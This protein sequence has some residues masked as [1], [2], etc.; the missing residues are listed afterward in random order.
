MTSGVQITPAAK[1]MSIKGKADY[2]VI[3][4][5]SFNIANDEKVGFDAKNYL[6][7][8]NDSKSS[9]IDGTLSGAGNIY[10]VNPNGVIFGSDS[11]VNVGNLS[12]STRPL[13]KVDR[14]AFLRGQDPLANAASNVGGD[15]VNL[16]DIKA[17]KVLLE[18]NT[19][20]LTNNISNTNLN[21]RALTGVNVGF[22]D[23][24]KPAT[25]VNKTQ[26]T[27]PLDD[28]SINNFKNS[29]NN[30]SFK[31]LDGKTD[32]SS[33]KF[34]P[35]YSVRNIY[36][37]QN[38]RNNPTGKYMLTD[39]IDASL[40]RFWNGEDFTSDDFKDVKN[41]KFEYSL[42]DYKGNMLKLD[43]STTGHTYYVAEL[44]KVEDFDIS[45]IVY[46]FEVTYS[47]TDKNNKSQK[48]VITL[49]IEPNAEG[50]DHRVPYDYYNHK[51]YI[52]LEDKSGTVERVDFWMDENHT[53][54][55]T[56]DHGVTST[57]DYYDYYYENGVKTTIPTE[58]PDTGYIN[59]NNQNN[60][61]IL[62]G[63]E[64]INDLT[65]VSAIRDNPE[66]VKKVL[67]AITPLTFLKADHF[68]AACGFYKCDF[69][70]E[71]SAQ[72]NRD[73]KD[74]SLPLGFGYV[75]DLNKEMINQFQ[76]KFFTLPYA[77]IGHESAPFSGMIDG[78]GFSLKNV[79]INGNT[80]GNFI[81]YTQGSVDSS[82]PR[83]SYMTAEKAIV[84]S[85]L[86]NV[87]LIGWLDGDY[88]VK[89]LTLEYPDII[90][91]TSKENETGGGLTVGYYKSG[92]L[93]TST[94]EYKENYWLLGNIDNPDGH[95]SGLN[96]ISQSPIYPYLGDAYNKLPT[97]QYTESDYTETDAENAQL[98][99]LGETALLAGA[100][101]M[102]ITKDN[103][104]IC[105]YQN[106][107]GSEGKA[108]NIVHPSS[109]ETDNKY[110]YNLLINWDSFNVGKYSSVL[111]D[112]GLVGQLPDGRQGTF[113]Y[114][115]LVKNPVTIEG[116]V[117]GGNELYLV[118][119]G[120]ITLTLDS[121]VNTSALYLS[122][123]D[124][125]KFNWEY[126]YK[127]KR[128]SSK[129]GF[130]G[131]A[132]VVKSE[133]EMQNKPDYITGKDVKEHAKNFTYKDSAKASAN[134]ELK[135]DI[136][137]FA[138]V[139]TNQAGMGIV[140]LEGKNI[141]T[142]NRSLYSSTPERYIVTDGGE[143]K[144][145]AADLHYANNGVRYTSSKIP[146][147]NNFGEGVSTKQF[148]EDIDVKGTTNR[149]G[150]AL[151]NTLYAYNI[152][153]DEERTL[154][155][156]ELYYLVRNV[157]ELQ[158]MQNNPDEQYLLGR[159]IDAS[160]TKNWNYG[161]GFAPIFG[162][163]A[164]KTSSI[165]GP[166]TGVFDGNGF[167]IKNMYINRPDDEGVGLFS[168]TQDATLK[169]VVFEGGSVTGYSN[170]GALIGT[171][172]G[173][174]V[175][176]TVSDVSVTGVGE[177]GQA[178]GG[179]VGS[180]EASKVVGS[181]HNATVAGTNE[182]YDIGGLVGAATDNSVIIGFTGEDTAI[183]AAKP[184][185]GGVGGLVGN[186]D[187][188][189]VKGYNQGTVSSSAGGSLGGLAGRIGNISTVSGFNIGN[190]G[191]ANTK[192]AGGLVGE[193]ANTN[194]DG[195]VL[196]YNLGT[197]SA[198]N[199][200]GLT[201]YISNSTWSS[202][203]KLKLAGE[204]TGSME[205]L[206]G[207]A[208]SNGSLSFTTWT[209]GI[210]KA[211]LQTISGNVFGADRLD[212]TRPDPSDWSKVLLDIEKMPNNNTTWYIKE[213]ESYP[214]LNKY[215]TS[216]DE[217]ILDEVVLP[218]DYTY[219]AKVQ[220]FNK[221][222]CQSALSE[223]LEGKPIKP[224][225]TGAFKIDPTASIAG[226][227]KDAGDY[228]LT[229]TWI[230][231]YKFNTNPFITATIKPRKL[232]LD[233][234]K[235]TTK[236]YYTSGFS[237]NYDGTTSSDSLSGSKLYLST[238]YADSSV[239]IDGKMVT[240]YAIKI[241]TTD[242]SSEMQRELNEEDGTK[243]KVVNLKVPG[244]FN[245]KNVAEAD[246]VTFKNGMTLG[247]SRGRNYI[248]DTTGLSGNPTNGICIEDNNIVVKNCKIK[249]MELTLTKT[250]DASDYFTKEYDGT[251]D[252]IGDIDLS[253]IFIVD[254]S[255]LT[256][257]L[258]E[259]I[260][261]NNFGVKITGL[262]E[263]KYVKKDGS[264]YVDDATAGKSKSVNFNFDNIEVVGETENYQLRFSESSGTKTYGNSLKVSDGKI[265]IS[266]IGIINPMVLKLKQKSDVTLSKEY[267]ATTDVYDSLGNPVTS[268]G[269]IFEIDKTGIEEKY[270]TV[271][272]DEI[273]N[274]KFNDIY[275]AKYEDANAGTD[276][277]IWFQYNSSS[278]PKWFD[279][280]NYT[281]ESITTIGGPYNR[282]V[283]TFVSTGDIT[284]K[285]LK[286]T[287]IDSSSLNKTYDGDTS[288]YTDLSEVFAIGELSS[289]E[290]E[291]IQNEVAQLKLNNGIIGVY[292]DANIGSGKRIL[293]GDIDTQWFTTKDSSSNV[294]A[295][296]Y[297]VVMDTVGDKKGIL[298][299]GSITPMNIYIE[300][301][302]KIYDGNSDVTFGTGDNADSVTL[303][304]FWGEDN[305]YF[306]LV[307]NENGG[308]IA[309]L[310]SGKDVIDN[311]YELNLANYSEKLS[312]VQTGGESGLLSNYQLV[313]NPTTNAWTAKGDIT[314]LT[315]KLTP[316]DS[317]VYD[318]KDYSS[319]DSSKIGITDE[320]GNI[321]TLCG[322]DKLIVET[323]STGINASGDSDGYV[324]KINN[325]AIDDG[326]GGK[327][328]TVSVIDG[329]LVITPKKI[330]ITVTDNKEYDGKAYTDNGS[331]K[332]IFTDENGNIITLCGNDKLSIETSSTGINASG[333]SDGYVLK[334]NNYTIDDG[335][336]G[337]NYVV[338]MS[339]GKLYIKPRTIELSFKGTPITK[340]YDGTTDTE[341][342]LSDLF[343]LYGTDGLLSE[344]YE[345][346]LKVYGKFADAEPGKNKVVDF[347]TTVG[348]NYTLVFKDLN[349]NI[350]QPSSIVGEI[351][352]KP[353]PPEP[354][355]PEPEIKSDIT[356]GTLLRNDS[357][358]MVFEALNVNAA[359]TRPSEDNRDDGVIGAAPN[360]VGLTAE[361][362]ARLADSYNK[363][364][365]DDSSADEKKKKKIG[366]KKSS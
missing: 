364:S 280:G 302:S 62:P 293:F 338:S 18:G 279:N 260:K 206:G 248:L 300:K 88:K 245:S 142:T 119:P 312:L 139:N 147:Y 198:T 60:I 321:I 75:Y 48:F 294:N 131:N 316:N 58:K 287:R 151:L 56:D 178:I 246:S 92:V 221:S 282:D 190:V 76:T 241:N 81:D 164:S 324:L 112:C 224:Q 254:T 207:K 213:E 104:K 337:K 283:A 157:Y 66:G 304:G 317:K 218:T 153:S 136:I 243:T 184:Q 46:G 169:N 25:E 339:D 176:G 107:D 55:K 186:A 113:N 349:G 140:Y 257:E 130:I 271:V 187:N 347:G 54:Q 102:T 126:I 133:D 239:R 259:E 309:G 305:Q 40:T 200:G 281:L 215:F 235:L 32:L 263:G 313:S 182:V 301:V 209:D 236:N 238:L 345:R 217:Y 109:V 149:W 135:G 98:P 132:L 163:G 326:N 37:L 34:S 144:I 43:S 275:S 274:L 202:D 261:N 97:V 116:G 105:T 170:V 192:Y 230:A 193:V 70:L 47:Y 152:G 320:N 9:R 251:A 161:A 189:T 318:G 214:L 166:F 95:I 361:N 33:D 143:I 212:W 84:T 211:K 272:L 82:D 4:W 266:G 137:N 3:N 323:S 306:K 2:N 346:L 315:I 359:M 156:S 45:Q 26:F 357:A 273:N 65:S 291:A 59:P 249:P 115:N 168:F 226:E 196:G 86:A 100:E 223:A 89:N 39:D 23:G 83:G 197:I 341:Q 295:G 319:N 110:E 330:N 165:G 94:A 148:Y 74:Y 284:P 78:L 358:S 117:K 20:T 267:D 276:K 303:A 91:T 228:K 108:L 232:Q 353:V 16:T 27:K 216:S 227:F 17:T 19:I 69:H 194:T 203:Y 73:G 195:T 269:S 204:T 154:S 334:I 172:M 363:V 30:F 233:E 201:G 185:N 5:R 335:N 79:Y 7:L 290:S 42:C 96:T 29:H 220:Q 253:N 360:G 124:T 229:T 52:L 24:D 175:E 327:N 61:F 256:D 22:T 51:T 332:V 231:P 362:Q 237:K 123:R 268:I 173:T 288:T 167:K 57:L 329:K 366:S 103:L 205:L 343:G 53:Y 174:I 36:E 355:P 13:S 191:S 225:S 350:L 322:N 348:S 150:A 298:A 352:G 141:T 244:E 297:T 90:T 118:S 64:K 171:A 354:I 177:Y 6:N 101:A 50:Y 255:K 146:E 10:L 31:A 63:G 325:Y 340:V 250:N 183:S 162:N 155:K 314:P 219:N 247:G 296:N 87:G 179:L 111:F 356:I 336:G 15:I 264:D 180:A 307:Y 331:A 49:G 208:G 333:D 129:K 127:N 134:F 67:A 41:E 35:Y 310:F 188:A 278:S 285:E 270:G 8:I 128:S 265:S 11:S 289:E 351:T 199:K 106:F 342:T 80:N 68:A 120:N 365:D 145:A 1:E 311:G 77:P 258:K 252:V 85:S 21:V 286:L 125:D 242:M 160:D 114:L 14:D 210:T 122:T 121:A 71:T 240:E 72:I 99:V 159:D 277:Q 234:T 262:R 328:Y 181:I 292:E 299:E 222:S 12:V 44:E 344:E 308:K 93:K 138:E 28:S 38:M 158:N